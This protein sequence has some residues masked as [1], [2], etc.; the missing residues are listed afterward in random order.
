MENTMS[1]TTTPTT[2][3]IY[4]LRLAGGR[5]YIGKTDNVAKQ[6]QEH[7]RGAGSSWTRKYPP[8]S[9]EKTFEGV[10]AVDEDKITKE[11]M[12]KY[13]IENVRGGSYGTDVLIRSQKVALEMEI[14]T[15]ETGWW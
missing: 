13:G 10:G 1:T 12:S 5:Y 14:W 3:T 2:P 7:L 8:I 9:I 11:Y 4:V 15:S 6:F